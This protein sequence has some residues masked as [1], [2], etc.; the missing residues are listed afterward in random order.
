[1]NSF[2]PFATGRRPHSCRNAT[3]TYEL[4]PVAPGISARTGVLARTNPCSQLQL[5]RH[6]HWCHNAI[7]EHAFVLIAPGTFDEM[8]VHA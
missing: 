4:V 8:D 2:T 1:M 7:R 3:L 6:F 5:A